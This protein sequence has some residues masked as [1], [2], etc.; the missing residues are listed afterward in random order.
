MVTK[1]QHLQAAS[2][3]FCCLQIGLNFI[4]DLLIFDW[5]EFWNIPFLCSEN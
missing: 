2:I 1:R 4:N 3:F 5:M